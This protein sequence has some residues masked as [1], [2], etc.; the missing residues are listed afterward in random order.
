MSV[1]ESLKK[2]VP[3]AKKKSEHVSILRSAL[4]FDATFPTAENKCYD[5]VNVNN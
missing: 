5:G 2:N 4:C 3:A 1:C